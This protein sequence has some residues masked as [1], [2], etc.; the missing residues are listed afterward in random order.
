MRPLLDLD[1]PEQLWTV[2]LK[3]GD[4]AAARRV[5]R[6]GSRKFDTRPTIVKLVGEVDMLT[7]PL[8]A[9]RLDEHL[10]EDAR[11]VVVELTGVTFLSASGLSV[12]LAADRCA[13]TRGVEFSLAGCDGIVRRVFEA[14]GLEN[15]FDFI[16]SRQ[17][18][19]GQD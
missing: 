5:L 6:I 18:L 16:D 19:A 3:P 17:A 1:Q 7:A 4:D 9:E 10:H 12:L 14:A 15:R 11:Q 2:P 8:L 13:R